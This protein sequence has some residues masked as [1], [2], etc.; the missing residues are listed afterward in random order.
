MPELG[1]CGDHCTYCPRFIATQ[2]QDPQMLQE[3]ADL[4]VR[5]G[6]RD[7][8]VTSQELKCFGCTPENNCAYSEQR[9][10]AFAKGFE[11]CGLCRDYPCR[12]VA[13]TIERTDQLSSSIRSLCSPKEWSQLE[14]AFFLK[15]QNLDAV[16]KP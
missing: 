7:K 4:W 1:A 9:D 12:I 10:C 11:N 16:K 14:K 15:K 6:L 13:A 5:I 2:N 3:V 8:S